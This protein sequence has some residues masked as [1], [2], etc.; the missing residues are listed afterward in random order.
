[1]V[2][3]AAFHARVR[4]SVPGLGGLKETI[5]FL[6]HPRV[7][8]SIVR[9]LRGREVACLA[10]NRQG[11]EFRSCFWRTVSSNSFYHPQKVLLAQFSL[12]MHKWPK[13][14]FILFF[15]LRRLPFFMFDVSDNMV[16]S[17]DTTHLT[18]NVIAN[19]ITSIF[20][21]S[22]WYGDDPFAVFSRTSSNTINSANVG[23]MLG[24][25]RRG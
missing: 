3:T 15:L 7:E 10:S 18:L 13:S 22:A 20:Y 14:Q 21:Y 4:G 9:S 23:V 12:Y 16:F 2:S 5:M 25:R 24:K 11:S 19:H 1:M 6:T 17:L 8:L